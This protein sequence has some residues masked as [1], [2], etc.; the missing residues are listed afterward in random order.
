[1][2]VVLVIAFAGGFLRS[3]LD[4]TKQSERERE[5]L[6]IIRSS[7]E[8]SRTP[9]QQKFSSKLHRE[10]SESRGDR[11][12]DDLIYGFR[13]VVVVL[14]AWSLAEVLNRKRWCIYLAGFVAFAYLPDKGNRDSLT[15]IFGL[16]HSGWFGLGVAWVGVFAAD[17]FHDT[18]YW[19][20]DRKQVPAP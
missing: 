12:I 9:E 14:F 2:I 17:H 16:L 11:W 1:M 10:L 19:S 4:E 5:I 18:T 6:H 7:P 8:H 15:V 20:K 13:A 3:N